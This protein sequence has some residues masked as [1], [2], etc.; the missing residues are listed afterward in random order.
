MRYTRLA[1]ALS[2][3]TA[4][5]ASA[6][7]ATREQ[8]L[9]VMSYNIQYG[10]EGLDSVIAVVRAERPDI[11]GLQ[12]L[13]VHWGERSSFVN[14]AELLAK[15][16]GMESRFAP[17]Y[18]IPN[19]DP[20]KPPREFG[21][22]VLSR[23]PIVS[24][25]NHVIARLSTQEENPVPKPLPGFLEATID[26]NGTKVRVFA[27]HLDYR[28]DPKV[29]VQQVSDML[30]VMGASTGPTLMLGDMNAPPDASELVPLLQ[31][32]RDTWPSKQGPGL[33]YSAKTPVKRIDYVLISDA[34]RVSK[35]WVTQVYASDHFPVV[36]NLVLT[37]PLQ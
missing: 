29:R 22:G 17:I 35:T 19:A 6:P 30:A 9:R 37:K 34:F 24:F 2:L 3:L 12:E 18:R 25:R 8:P 32:L 16:T 21:V 4:A 23:Y 20:T 26:V 13:D 15:G 10:N 27:V 36:V 33:T 1:A 31:R 5:C 28:P 7:V 14:Q 11:V